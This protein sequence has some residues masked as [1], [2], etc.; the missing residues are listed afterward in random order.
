LGDRLFREPG[1][2]VGHVVDFFQVI[3]FPAIFNVADAAIVSSMG[4]FII[5]SL[6]GIGLDGKRTTR[7]AKVDAENVQAEIEREP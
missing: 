3:G 2:G 4:L 7:S 6:R 5:L 1:F